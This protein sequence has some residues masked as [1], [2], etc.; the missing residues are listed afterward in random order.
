M[1]I[2]DQIE[3]NKIPKHTF[4]ILRKQK[5]TKQKYKPLYFDLI[6]YSRVYAS[7]PICP[8]QFAWNS[9]RVTRK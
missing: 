7:I 4:I 2:I 3:S 6:I 5:K 9:P 8:K 1:K